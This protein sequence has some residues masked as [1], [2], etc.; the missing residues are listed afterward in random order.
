[1]N[2]KKIGAFLGADG[3]VYLRMWTRLYRVRDY[4]YPMDLE[5]YAA[6]EKKDTLWHAGG[7]SGSYRD[8]VRTVREREGI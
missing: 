1:M 2:E 8:L 7:W 6:W 3:M 4:K 5:L